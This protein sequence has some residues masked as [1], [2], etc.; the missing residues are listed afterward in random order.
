M[1]TPANVTGGPRRRRGDLRRY[2]RRGR[3]RRALR[4]PADLVVLAARAT[5]TSRGGGYLVTWPSALRRFL[6][7]TT[8]L[9]LVEH[10]TGA[11]GVRRGGAPRHAAERPDRRGQ[12]P[13][14]AAGHRQ[15]AAAG[16]DLRHPQRRARRAAAGLDRGGARPRCAKAGIEAFPAYGTLLGAVR[17][18]R[19]IGHD[20]DADLGYVSEHTHPVDVMRESFRLQRALADMGYRD[21]PLQR[22]RVQGRRGRGR[23][24]GARPRR[25][26]RLPARRPPAPD[27]RDPHAVRAGVD[28]PARHHHAG[29]PRRC[30]RRR[31]PTS[32]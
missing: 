4:R 20:S 23:R 5:A 3:P 32:S 13:R 7:G 10:V 8:A 15:V 18:G 9:Q 29:G 16:A 27:G 19:L 2:R 26:R 31:T 28:L 25:L 30:R 21:H 11:R 1:S 12:R 24:L 6:D 14:A 17:G 22:R